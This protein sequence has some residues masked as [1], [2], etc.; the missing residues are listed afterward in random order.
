MAEPN[1]PTRPRVAA[2]DRGPG[3]GK[4]AP[5]M[6]PTWK[7]AA[8]YSFGNKVDKDIS[9][10]DD[11]PGP[12]YGVSE[13]M[14]TKGAVRNPQFS[15]ASRQRDP[16]PF[17]TPGPGSYQ[18]EKCPV[19][20]ERRSSAFVM[21]MRT[22]YRKRDQV[23]APSQYSLP[24]TMGSKLTTSNMRASRAFG[25][26]SKTKKGGY[27]EDLAGTPGP[28]NY[29]THNDNT[30]R[31]RAPIPSLSTR[32]YIPGDPTLKPGPGAYSPEK[33]NIHKPRAPGFAVGVKHS[34]YTTPLIVE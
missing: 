6:L 21:G 9:K 13:E 7:T 30:T 31:T 32:T 19:P 15:L 29:A 26:N 18:V 1:A 34:E 3:S 8:K 12:K 27:D 11:S 16:I 5:N 20:G 24:A 23:P 25:F 28:N 14:T 22:R 17:N 10:I 4:Y 2:M 33:V